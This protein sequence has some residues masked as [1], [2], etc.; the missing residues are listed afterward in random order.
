MPTRR[1][2]HLRSR[3][4]RVVSSGGEESCVLTLAG[5]RSAFNEYQF[6]ELSMS[7]VFC[8]EAATGG[9]IQVVKVVALL[10]MTI[11]DR[12]DEHKEQ[13]CI[14]LLRTRCGNFIANTN[15]GPT[16]QWKLMLMDNHGTHCTPEFIK[17]ANENHI[18]PLLLIPHLTHCM[19]PLDVG[20]FQPYKY[21]HD[22]AI[23]DVLAEFNIEGD[24]GDEDEQFNF[25]QAGYRHTRSYY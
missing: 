11:L 3:Q 13:I 8:D 12:Q 15:S 21:W 17:L 7:S 9:P 16:K 14:H 1:V 23:Q 20:V 4:K 6:L 2:Q 25:Y 10:A 19:Q 5:W 22:K 24:E 18:R